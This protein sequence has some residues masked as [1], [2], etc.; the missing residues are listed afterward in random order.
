MSRIEEEISHLE[1]Q[2][3]SPESSSD[4]QLL[5]RLGEQIGELKEKHDNA[6]EE[7]IELDDA[8]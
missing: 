2:M 7:W 4:Y 6:M 5:A 1:K 8:F 3:S